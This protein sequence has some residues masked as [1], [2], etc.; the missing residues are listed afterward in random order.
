MILFQLSLLLLGVI[1]Y[2]KKP[3]YIILY[4]LSFTPFAILFFSWKL[5]I[6]SREDL[7]SLQ[8]YITGLTRNFFG[9]L[10]II[11]I[12]KLKKL[13]NIIHLII[14]FLI[15]AIF[16]ALHSYM[17]VFDTSIVMENISEIAAI[18]LP[19]YFF[20]IDRNAIPTQSKLLKYMCILLGI[21][22]VAAIINTQGIYLYKAFYTTAITSTMQQ[23]YDYENSLIS[24]TFPRY[25]MLANYISTIYVFFVLEFLSKKEKKQ[26]FFIAGSIIMLAIITLSGAKA[27][28]FLSFFML[29]LTLIIYGKKNVGL[30]ILFSTISLIVFNFLLQYNYNADQ[31]T[32]MFAGFFRQ[33]QGFA[34]IAQKSQDGSTLSISEYLIKKYFFNNPF[35]GN[36]LAANGEYAYGFFAY[37]GLTAFKADARIAFILVEYGVIG[38]LL[39]TILFK[40]IYDILSKNLKKGAKTKLKICFLYFFILT[41]TEPGFFD[42]V[43]FPMMYLYVFAFLKKTYNENN[44]QEQQTR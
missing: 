35:L 18:I 26:K 38:F 37:V 16:F 30:L 27:S 12:C 15:M 40:F 24:G 43:C 22:C 21:E 42:R 23:R 33:I 29:S 44:I 34:A 25:N 6:Y 10:I 17:N 39:Y 13:P 32:E 2:L 4:W 8:Y 3:Q 19:L 9:I 41:I 11:A 5:N 20:M 28:L 1:I 31:Q 36:G 7:A 14:L